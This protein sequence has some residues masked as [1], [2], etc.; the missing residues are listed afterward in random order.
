MQRKTK[1]KQRRDFKKQKE[2]K[3]IKCILNIKSIYVSLIHHK[4]IKAG[5]PG[6]VGLL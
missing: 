5:L 1:T 4:A 6:I 2:T 3:G